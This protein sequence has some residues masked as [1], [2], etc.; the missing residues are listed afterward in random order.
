MAE[1]AT[2]YCGLII[3]K[4]EMA[5]IASEGSDDYIQHV[6]EDRMSRMLA[7]DLIE[8]EERWTFYDDEELELLVEIGNFITITLV[9][10]AGEE[11]SS[12]INFDP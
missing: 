6:Q 10:E 8:G 9:L 4:N 2:T 12:L 11:I 1:I 7:Q 5:R 3:E